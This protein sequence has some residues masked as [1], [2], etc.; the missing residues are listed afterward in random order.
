MHRPHTT[1]EKNTLKIQV[2]NFMS[3]AQKRLKRCLTQGGVVG[4]LDGM[5]RD[6]QDFHGVLLNLAELG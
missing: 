4:I 2:I 3:C 5:R 6:E 1:D